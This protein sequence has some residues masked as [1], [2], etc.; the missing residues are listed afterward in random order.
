M[1]NS[2]S[3]LVLVLVFWVWC[4]GTNELMTT[5]PPLVVLHCTVL[6]YFV[7]CLY[8][9]NIKINIKAFGLDGIYTMGLLQHRTVSGQVRFGF[10]FFLW[11]G[12]VWYGRQWGCILSRLPTLLS[13]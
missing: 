11:S 5:P 13:R 7:V 2:N 12:L 3:I 1:R 6:Y 9:I 10:G 8:N 4:L